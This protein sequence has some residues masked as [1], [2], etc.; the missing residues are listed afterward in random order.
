MDSRK[1]NHYHFII[2]I[3]LLFLTANLALGDREKNQKKEIITPAVVIDHFLDSS[4]DTES[5]STPYYEHYDISPDG[6]WVAFTIKR[7]LKRDDIYAMGDLRKL[8]GGIPSTFIRQD[9]WIANTKTRKLKRLTNGKAGK[10]SFW[11]PV[12]SPNSQDIAFYGD[13]KGRIV[14]WLCSSAIGKNP[15]VKPI[16]GL[17]LKSQLFRRDLPRWTK[18]GKK[19]I[20]PIIPEIEKNVKP[21]IDGNPYY[22]IPS[23]YQKFLD[24]NGGAT[25]NILR[26]NDESDTNRSYK[27]ENRVALGILDTVSGE[28]RRLTAGLDI[29]MWELSPDG[30]MIAFKSFKE[31]AAGT[32]NRIFDLYIITLESGSVRRHT[33]SPRKIME[34]VERGILWSPDSNFLLE[35]QR[36]DLVVVNVQTGEKKVITPGRDRSFEKILPP[37]DILRLSGGSYLWSPEGNSVLARNKD[38]WWLLSLNGSPPERLFEKMDENEKIRGILRPKMKGYAFSPD[39]KSV[40]LESFNPKKSKM[41]FFNANLTTGQI[42]EISENVPNYASIFDLLRIKDKIFILYSLREM[43]VSNLWFSDI[44][45]AKPI[46]LTNLNPHLMQVPRGEVKLFY[47]RNLD[48]RKLKGALLLPVNYEEGKRYPLI[49]NVYAGYTVSTPERSFPMK[50]HPIHISHLLSRCGYVVLRPSIPLSPSGQKGSPLKEIPKSVLPAVDKVI[51]MGIADPE[52]LGII[53]QSYGGYTVYALITQTKRFKAAISMGGMCDLVSN[54]GIFNASLRYSNGGSSFTASWSEG[55]QG[56][57]GVPLWEDRFQWIENS[58]IFYLNRVETPLLILHGDLDLVSIQQSEEMFSGLKRLNKE[59]ELVRYFGEG[60]V[61]SKPANIR[62]AWHRIVT[63]F[64][65]HLKGKK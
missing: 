26:S 1:I 16:K 12:W 64:D 44:S 63:W 42:K 14:L 20:I 46:K 32:F 57:M 31:C 54:Y 4:M 56:R 24:P 59:V 35:R 43:G 58:P 62:D 37:P 25:A 34:N 18:D 52:R 36:E 3:F 50:F 13:K 10:N 48:G 55:G 17:P 61:L 45:F 5:I 49:A 6:R 41:N 30:Q 47:H 40:I 7:G 9:I 38:G 39:G 19:L 27:M 65:M 23:L 51:E 53:G 22:L 60:H 33:S 29:I 28:M 15:T 2:M 11:H 8:P 21:G